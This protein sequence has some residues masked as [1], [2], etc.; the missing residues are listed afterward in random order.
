M[1]IGIDLGTSSVKVLL[2]SNE[3]QVI[4]TVS[5]KY[6]VLMPKPSWTEQNPQDWFKQTI[7][8]LKKIVGG[9]ENEIKAISFSGQ[10]HGLV[11]LDKNDNVI[12]NALLWNDQRTT[13]EVEKLEREI[14]FKKILE[15]TGNIVVTGLTA[16]KILWVYNNEPENF[17]KIAKIMLPKDYLAYK[18]SG[19]FATDISDV[20]GTGYYDVAN[21]RYS[22]VMLK[23]LHITEEQLPVV[24]E[25]SDKIGYLNEQLKKEL[26]LTRDVKI[27]IGGGDQAVGAIGVG[28]VLD[29]DTSISLGTSGVVFKAS[30]QFRIDTDSYMQSYLHANGKYHMIG[31]TLNTTGVLN[32]WNQKI[33]NVFDYN[34]FF[35]KA[36]EANY[37]DNL[38]FLP[39]L[40]GERFP[41]NDP[42]AQGVFIGLRQEQTKANLDLAVIE[43]ITFNIK[44]IFEKVQKIG[45]KTTSIKV[46]G[47]GAKSN[48]WVQLLA[49]ILNVK[50]NT[51]LVEEGPALG[52]AILAMVGDDLYLSLNEACQKI[53]KIKKEFIPNPIKVKYYQKKYEGYLK[54]YP[55]VKKLF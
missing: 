41:I 27:I 10:M 29:G 11:I 47:G 53:V 42:Q 1:Y 9:F 14:G 18:L 8:A 17:Q 12:R 46:T 36:L 54:I 24:Y 40:S 48:Y 7:I 39:Y 15:E 4:K 6:D 5:Q 37:Q 21:K 45:V 43:G 49:D 32:W 30:N 23:A 35:K 3:G 55:I 22:S 20:S 44:Q 13:L 50:L 38:Y 34:V 16:P 31:V 19:V 33:S 52:A 26:K 28:V 2:L 51:I 25:S